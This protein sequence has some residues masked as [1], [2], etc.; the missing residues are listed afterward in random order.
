[1]MKKRFMVIALVLTMLVPL[2]AQSPEADFATEPDG[3]G[4]V[5]IGYKGKAATL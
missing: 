5:V 4:V 3:G 2:A 1:M